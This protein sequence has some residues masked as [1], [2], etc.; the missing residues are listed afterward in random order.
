M[1]IILCKLCLL[2][3]KIE[4]LPNW[5]TYSL[6]LNEITILEYQ[7]VLLHLYLLTVLLSSKIESS[8][9]PTD[10]ELLLARPVLV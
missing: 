1:E 2:Y 4:T 6:R 7:T 10:I 5:L 9:I 8:I 3:S